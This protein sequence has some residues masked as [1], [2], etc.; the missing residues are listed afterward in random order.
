MANEVAKTKKAGIANYL[1]I[2]SVKNQIVELVGE[3]QSQTFI[4]SIVSACQTNK[5][6]QNCSP[7]SIVS[8]ALMGESLHLT[9]SPQM[10]QY[11]I[12]PYKN[13]ATFQMGAKGF[14]Q[15]AIRSGQYKKIVTSVIKKGELKTFNPITEEY[16]FEPILDPET[17]EG[18]P[19]EGYYGMFILNNGFQKE[20]YW[21]K[22]KMFAHAKQ[23]SQG[24]RSDLKNG[25]KYT[26]WT[27]QF[28][29]MA[30]KTIIR[31]LISKWGIMSIDMQRAFESDMGVLKTDGTVDYIDNQPDSAEEV[32]AE[33]ENSVVVDMDAEVVE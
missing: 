17:R 33:N 25:T 9:P 10:G 15:L 20:I 16:V 21:S 12:V 1:T 6:L 31:Q 2:P 28:D 27:K 26:Y 22:E 11:Y 24:Y 23:Y 30:E 32:I 5:E 18:L 19:V 7:S 13:E 8:A 14:K 29:D 4:A 3:K